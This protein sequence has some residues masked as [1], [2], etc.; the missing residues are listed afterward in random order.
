MGYAIARRS[1]RLIK[2]GRE[3]VLNQRE[4][5]TLLKLG[6][7]HPEFETAF[8]EWQQFNA[9]MLDMAE[10]AGLIDPK[11]R[12]VWE[13]NDYTPFYRVFQET[14]GVVGPGRTRGLAGQSS[15]I[16]TLR[17]GEAKVNDLVENM[18]REPASQ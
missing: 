7:E 2:E 6:E 4:I 15:G 16:K 12:A 14:E 3:K 17:G 8:Q 18:M 1:K 11:Q 13:H 9:A 10:E 5:D